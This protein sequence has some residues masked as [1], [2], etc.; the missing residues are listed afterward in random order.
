MHI[1]EYYQLL[2][3]HLVIE[4]LTDVDPDVVPSIIEPKKPFLIG[5]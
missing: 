1:T 2:L 4:T 5:P 3:P